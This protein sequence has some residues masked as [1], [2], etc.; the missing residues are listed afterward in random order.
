MAPDHP[1]RRRGGPGPDRAGRPAR[2]T[3]RRRPQQPSWRWSL[4]FLIAWPLIVCGLTFGW[5][6]YASDQQDHQWCA[7]FDALDHG[8]APTTAAGLKIEHALLARGRS[9]GC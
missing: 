7:L 3:L 5:T 8:P 6:T 9:L 4:G 2:V 1:E